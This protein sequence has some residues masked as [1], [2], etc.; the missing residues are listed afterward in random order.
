[1]L[2]NGTDNAYT[3]LSQESKPSLTWA[4]RPASL[5][6]KQVQPEAYA[7]PMLTMALVQPEAVYFCCLLCCIPIAA[8]AAAAAV[9]AFAGAGS[10]EKCGRKT[11]G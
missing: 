5:Y 7:L 11:A 2:S 9:A 10:C 1:M 6:L 4:E 8:A 3:V